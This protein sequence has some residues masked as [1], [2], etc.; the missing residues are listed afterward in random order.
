[1]KLILGRTIVLGLLAVSIAACGGGSGGGSNSGPTAV[2][3][4]YVASGDSSSIE[5]FSETATGNAS[6]QAT[7]SGSNTTL[8][9]PIGVAVDSSGVIYVAGDEAVKVFAAGSSGNVAPTRTISGSN[10]LLAEPEGIAIS[11]SGQVAVGAAGGTTVAIFNETSSGNVAPVSYFTASGMSNPRGVAFDSN[12]NLWVTSGNDNAVFEFSASS[13][14]AASGGITPVNEISGTSTQI[15]YPLGIAVDSTGRIIVGN[16]YS[17]TITIFSSGASG[18]ATPVAVI[19]GSNTG[20]VNPFYMALSGDGNFSVG[21]NSVR[22]PVVTYPC[23]TTGGN[24]SP[25]YSLSSP[26]FNYPLSVAYH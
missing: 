17:N 6:P 11:S 13:I 5:M 19:S 25:T 2:K 8:K 15:D 7:I 4:L 3:T 18:N 10:T 26:E 24:I 9:L 23:S 1:M 14:A 12:G 16:C 20:L 22:G 21:A